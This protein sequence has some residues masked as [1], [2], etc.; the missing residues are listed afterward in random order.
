M[1]RA[2]IKI[3]YLCNNQCLFCVQGDRRRTLGNRPGEDI[4]KSIALAKKQGCDEIVFTG[5]EATLR[6]DF[7]DLVAYAKRQRFKRI[8]IQTNGRMFAYLDMCKKAV[9]AGANE[10]S[11][12][13]HGDT[14]ELHDHLTG[15]PGSFSQTVQ[16]IRNLKMLGQRVITNSV[17]TKPNYKRLPL[18]AELLVSLGVDQ[19]QFAFVH[20]VGS[21]AVNHKEIVPKVSLIMPYVKKGLDIGINAGVSV[22]TEAIPY[23]LMRGYEQYVAERVIPDGMVI[24]YERVIDDYREYRNTIG[25]AKGPA[26]KKCACYDGC[27]GPWKEYP[28]L[29]GW[30]EFK[31]ILN[32]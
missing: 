16:A 21:A 26:C 7:I 10:F 1:K 5:G 29:Y 25:K 3:G 15:A 14:A 32:T 23:C 24:E 9:A 28:E 2:D 6:D 12:A 31:P 27:E 22:M 11:P 13:L 19:Y 8:Q 17:I 18:L 4:K 30:K 20:I